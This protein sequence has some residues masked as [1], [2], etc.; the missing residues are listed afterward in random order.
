M[1]L[2]EKDKVLCAFW[3]TS[4]MLSSKVW[5]LWMFKPR[6]LAEL[7]L[8]SACPWM[9]KLDCSGVLVA[10]CRTLH[11]F[12]WICISH[13]SSHFC[14]V[15]RSCCRVR[16]SFSDLILDYLRFCVPLKNVSLVWR[17]HHCQWRAAKYRPMLG[18][19]C[20]WAGRYFYHAMP[21]VTRDLGFSLFIWRIGPIQ[22]FLMTHME[23]WTIYSNPN[24]HGFPFNRLLRHTRER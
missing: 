19:L 15:S 12:G 10:I 13:W 11:L 2:L 6:Y 23:M 24:L 3:V 18:A 16:R 17:R 14:N 7:P 1:F 8:F 9:V 21:V 22:L 20:L 4:L 5:V